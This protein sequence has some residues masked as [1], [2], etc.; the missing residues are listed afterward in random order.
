MIS[1]EE[2]LRLLPDESDRVERTT[3]TTD[4]DKFAE[5]V[6]AFANDLPNHRQPGYLIVGARDDGTLN[7]LRVSDQLLQNLAA[8]RSDG[9][10]QP[11]PALNVA[12][13]A[14]PEGDLAVV[15]VHPSDL[16]P[17][18]YKGRIYIRV[19]T[20]RGIANE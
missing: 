4:T 2:L 15:E 7:G 9:N 14:F 3:S 19:G 6:T 8:L 12:K 11:L 16:P 10:I 18:R 20:R 5:A 17:V 13:F 1:P